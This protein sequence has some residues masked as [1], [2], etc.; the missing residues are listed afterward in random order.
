MRPYFGRTY[1]DN[2]VCFCCPLMSAQPRHIPQVDNRTCREHVSTLPAMSI[3]RQHRACVTRPSAL[4]CRSWLCLLEPA[5][6]N[7]L[8]TFLCCS[9]AVVCDRSTL[10][11]DENVRIVSFK[12]QYLNCINISHV[13]CFCPETRPRNQDIKQHEENTNNVTTTPSSTSSSG[14]NHEFVAGPRCTAVAS[15]A[16]G[17]CDPSSVI[18][19]SLSFAVLCMRVRFVTRL[20]R[21]AKN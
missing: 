1:G 2:V 20:A 10:T 19:A 7:P 13:L 11:L 8:S 4:Y 18:T 9:N 14:P 5:V 3:S 21:A 16:I 15:C 17:G 12:Y 6:R